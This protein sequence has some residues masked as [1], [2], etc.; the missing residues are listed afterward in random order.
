MS[1]PLV[2]LA[3]DGV[4]NYDSEESIKSPDEWKAIPGSLPA[5]ARLSQNGYRVVVATN[6]GGLAKRLLTIEDFISINHKMLS[7]LAQYGGAIEAIAFCP[8]GP[9][10]SNCDC[11]KPKPGM[12]LDIAERL[13]VNLADIPYVGD[14]LIDVQAAKAAKARPVLVRTGI[15]EQLF[16]NNKVPKDVPVYAS[17]ADFVDEL[18]GAA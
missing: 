4:I 13:R 10:D 9:R 5:I 3:R 17:L 16:N 8:C 7:H 11:R 2:I 12:L 15:N 14:K 18:L 1:S 6:Q